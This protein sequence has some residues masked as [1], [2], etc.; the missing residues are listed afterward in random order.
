MAY[1]PYI[2][3]I[4]HFSTDA[5]MGLVAPS[6]LGT[7][8]EFNS[9]QEV[10]NQQTLF[11][12]RITNAD[13]TLKNLSTATAQALAGTQEFVATAS[14]TLFVTTIPYAAAFSNLNVMVYSGSSR[15]ARR[16][17]SRSSRVAALVEG[18][19]PR[20]CGSRISRWRVTS[21]C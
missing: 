12:R 14:Q 1:P 19:I 9:I 17:K 4:T 20:R 7:D 16:K 10:Q 3:R 6:A 21:G 13:G 8:A 2:A 11:I 15:F 18:A 5:L